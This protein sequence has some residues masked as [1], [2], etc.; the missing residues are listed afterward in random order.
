MHQRLCRQLY[1]RPE[2]GTPERIDSAHEEKTQLHTKNSEVQRVIALLPNYGFSC[3]L[4]DPQVEK[5][6]AKTFNIRWGQ[7]TVTLKPKIC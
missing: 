4:V 1:T 3:F 6:A 2:K 5:G 7:A